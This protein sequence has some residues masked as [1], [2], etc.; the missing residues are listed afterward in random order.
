MTG[1]SRATPR[2]LHSISAVERDTG[3][4][5]DTL[6]VW[7]RRYQFPLPE[8]DANGERV[9]TP[10]QVEKLRAL[11]RLIDRGHRPSKIVGQSLAD[12]L[13]IVDPAQTAAEPADP[14]VAATIKLLRAHRV[15]DLRQ[16][17]AQ[18]L[19]RDGLARFCLETVGPLTRQVGEAWMRG[20]LEVF[21]EHLYTETVQGL[22]RSTLAAM[23]A[24][25]GAPRVLLTT[26]PNEQHG[27]GLLMAESILALEGAT[28]ISL[29]TQTP[30]WDIV[31]AARTHDADIIALSFSL[32]YPVTPAVEGLEELRAKV[33]KSVEVWAGGANPGLARR[34]VDGVTALPELDAIPDAVA[35]W[36]R[37][38]GIA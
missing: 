30:I 26:F 10:E 6:R 12:L 28:C 24:A 15:A 2:P 32:A 37:S 5:K 25:R 34:A 21:E 14:A 22:L 16:G 13:A 11:K 1:G 3:L 17:L 23:P 38:R 19:M 8:R 31:L 36:R 27:L 20:Q 35:R 33:A 29:G 4:S 7:E 18:R 9:Y